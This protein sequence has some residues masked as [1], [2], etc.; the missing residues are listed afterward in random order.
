MESEISIH[1]VKKRSSSGQLVV[2]ALFFFW[3]IFQFFKGV[4]GKRLPQS[5][6]WS[7][8]RAPWTSSVNAK[9]RTDLG[10]HEGKRLRRAFKQS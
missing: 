1:L 4:H 7:G 8:K 3:S 9:R 10:F 2:C 6:G 5:Q